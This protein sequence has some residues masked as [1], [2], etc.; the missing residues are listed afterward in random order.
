VT[1]ALASFRRW[2][3]D[4]LQLVFREVLIAIYPAFAAI[5]LALFVP[6]NA[7]TVELTEFG[8]LEWT[9]QWTFALIATVYAVVA[10]WAAASLALRSASGKERPGFTIRTTVPFWLAALVLVSFSGAVWTGTTTWLTWA[11]SIVLFVIPFVPFLSPKARGIHRKSPSGHFH[12]VAWLHDVWTGRVQ[13]SLD[14]VHGAL[15]AQLRP[16]EIVLLSIGCAVLAG[17]IVSPGRVPRLIGTWALVYVALGFWPLLGSRV[18]VAWPRARHYPSLWL[19]PLVWMIVCSVNNENH[20]VRYTRGQA[21]HVRSREFSVAFHDWIKRR[22]SDLATKKCPMQIVAAEGGGLR[23]AYWTAAVLK[24]L[25]DGT[26]G[27]FT[28]SVFAIS[29]VS[30]GSLGAVAYYG[31]RTPADA[32]LSKQSSEALRTFVGDD[33]LSALVAG[34]LYTNQRRFVGIRP[35]LA[36]AAVFPRG[37]GRSHVV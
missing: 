10:T 3:A 22:C 7:Q 2:Y 11:A 1:S 23:A 13:T 14:R 17:C 37:S 9:W 36:A 15:L 6:R 29:S 4:E 21:G 19:L 31:A 16:I 26:N 18:F 8:P 27:A 32:T 34:L 24:R 20:Q 33:H 30:G 25:D 12:R 35:I 28:R 5:L